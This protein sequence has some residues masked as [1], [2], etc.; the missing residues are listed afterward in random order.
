M[1]FEYEMPLWVGGVLRWGIGAIHIWPTFVFSALGGGL[2]SRG[3]S[4][5]QPLNRSVFTLSLGTFVGYGVAHRLAV[6]LYPKIELL[7]VLDCE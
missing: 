2:Q 3:T 6:S 1:E 4:Q 5:H 7:E